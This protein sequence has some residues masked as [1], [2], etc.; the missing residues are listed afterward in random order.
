[1]WSPI[2]RGKNDILLKTPRRISGVQTRDAC[3]HD[4]R[5]SEAL[6]QCASSN[7]LREFR[8]HFSMWFETVLETI[9]GLY[10]GL[11]EQ[12]WTFWNISH[13]HRWLKP[14]FFHRCCCCRFCTCLPP[15]ATPDCH[16]RCPPPDSHSCSWRK[17]YSGDS[18]GSFR[19]PFPCSFW[20][21]RLQWL[22]LKKFT[23]LLLYSK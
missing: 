22:L 6:C 1:M 7:L 8:S 18:F 12:G 11:A 17:C 19:L 14:P 3:M 4:W 2:K 23:L 5:G 21:R 16:R 9:L 10:T 20:H 15:R 13:R